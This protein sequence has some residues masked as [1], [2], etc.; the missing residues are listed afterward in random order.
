[1]K[2]S[3]VAPFSNKSL[4]G[5]I[6][7]K[8]VK[9][10]RKIT[11]SYWHGSKLKELPYEQGQEFDFKQEI[12]FRIVALCFEKGYSVQIIP[13]EQMVLIYIGVGKMITK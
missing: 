4:L 1:M 9:K 6:N 8:V 7:P 5:V 13:G 12:L 3:I 11:V 2:P 10:S